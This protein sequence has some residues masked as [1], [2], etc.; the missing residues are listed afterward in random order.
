MAPNPF[1]RLGAA[2]SAMLRYRASAG[3]TP[4]GGFGP[5]KPGFFTPAGAALRPTCGQPDHGVD[6]ALPADAKRPVKWVKDYF[7]WYKSLLVAFSNRITGIH[8]S[9]KRS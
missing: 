4:M 5:A 3:T 8:L 1:I 7:L 2:R 6:R 9:W